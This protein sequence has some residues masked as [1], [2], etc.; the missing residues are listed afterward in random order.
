M[1]WV[2]DSGID[3]NYAIYILHTHMCEHTK[4]FKKRGL[5]EEKNATSSTSSWHDSLVARMK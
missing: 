4:R 5:E 3:V 1:R 2:Y